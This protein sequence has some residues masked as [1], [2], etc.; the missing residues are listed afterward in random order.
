MESLPRLIILAETREILEAAAPAIRQ[1]EAHWKPEVLVGGLTDL[2]RGISRALAGRGVP[3]AV[4][5]GEQTALPAA[6]AAFTDGPVLAMP[7]IFEDDAATAASRLEAALGCDAAAPVA[8]LPPNRPEALV[9]MLARWRAVSVPRESTYTLDMGLAKLAPQRLPAEDE[10]GVIDADDWPARPPAEEKILEAPRALQEGADTEGDRTRREAAGLQDA[11]QRQLR[12]IEQLRQERAIRDAMQDGI[13][14]T[15]P[16]VAE[17]APRR[18]HR[19]AHVAATVAGPAQVLPAH[20]GRLLDMQEGKPAPEA[21]DRLQE[22]LL[23]GG[24][25]ALPTDAGHVLACDASH[26]EAIHRI[27]L[28]AEGDRPRVR[29]GSMALMVGDIGMLRAIVR[30]VPRDAEAVLER[31]LPSPLQLIFRRP[32]AMFRLA[33]PGETIALRQPDSPL[34]ERLVRRMARPVA[35]SQ[36]LM[37]NGAHSHDARRVFDRVGDVV[38]LVVRVPVDES[39][40]PGTLTV[41]DLSVTPFVLLAE[42]RVP[43]RALLALLGDR[44]VV[45]GASGAEAESAP[46]AEEAGTEG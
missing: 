29:G 24:I 23:E 19:E 3:V 1:I 25:A 8:V 6:V 46:T 45:P 40:P 27:Q 39:E 2:P 7:M 12:E 5:F 42:G 31:L 9:A 20:G 43:K 13:F 28:L 22:L 26:A 32:K 18:E 4:F 33:A 36:I 10:A 21:I 11:I 15:P 16:R 30:Q 44:L 38:D 17:P 14:T 34:W 41:L 35:V 37:E